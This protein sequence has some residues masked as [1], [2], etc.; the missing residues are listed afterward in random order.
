M[1]QKY[2]LGVDIGGTKT[3]FGVVSEKGVI[4]FH[5]EVPTRN[6]PTA[7]SLIGEIYRQISK[8][9]YTDF[10]GIGVLFEIVFF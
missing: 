4:I 7:E 9:S 10:F 1:D 5:G 3:A 2:A 8:T 6:Y